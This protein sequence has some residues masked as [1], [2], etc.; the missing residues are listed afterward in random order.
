MRKIIAVFAVAFLIL[1]CSGSSKTKSE[2]REA[3]LQE[4][5]EAVAAKDFEIDVVRAYPMR[6]R[7]VNLSGGYGVKIAGDSVYSYLPYFGQA[8]SVPYGGGEGL[9]F[10]S[11]MNNYQVKLGK[12]DEQIVSFR[13]N[14]NEDYYDFRMNIWSDGSGDITVTPGRKQPISFTGNMVMKKYRKD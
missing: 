14:T 3:D 2:S 10:E 11:V 12:R 5:R 8:Y 6:G 1:S 4:V 13:A 7:T 9:R